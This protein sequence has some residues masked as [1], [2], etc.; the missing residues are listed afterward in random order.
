MLGIRIQLTYQFPGYNFVMTHMPRNLLITGKPGIGKTT[1]VKRLVGILER[2]K[3]G[4][5]TEEIRKEGKR[6][7][8]CITTFSGKQGILA[9]D[10]LESKFRVGKYGVDI[11]VL[12]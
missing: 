3:C 6:R 8:F 9:C 7:G 2:P 11:G 4:F 5:I 12:D 1:L 10:D